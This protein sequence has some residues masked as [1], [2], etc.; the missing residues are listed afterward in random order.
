MQKSNKRFEIVD[1][2]FKFPVSFKKKLNSNLINTKMKRFAYLLMIMMLFSLVAC[3]K[4]MKSKIVGTWQLDS[5]EGEELT[6]SEKTATM[7]FAK[8]GSCER[9]RG[10][11]S[12]K[13]TWELDKEG[14]VITT[15]FDG[16]E[17]KMN[18]V[19]VEK[20]MM[21]FKIKDQKITLKMKK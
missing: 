15:K 21:S 11:K 12:E 9:S 1:I 16:E 5:V 19:T 6:D 13:G 17:E 14:K 2:F 4:D 3:K 8:D 20:E 18:D 10:D 7:T